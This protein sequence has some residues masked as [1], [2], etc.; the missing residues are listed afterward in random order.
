MS[1]TKYPAPKRRRWEVQVE[2]LDGLI[3]DAASDDDVVAR[4][5]N[6]PSWSDE[7]AMTDPVDWMNRVLDR[8]RTFYHAGLIGINGNSTPT[9]ILDALSA[10]EC[11]ILRRKG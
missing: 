2:F 6:F 9:E 3:I 8:A 5:R 11:I 4:W 7:S 10:E 1:H